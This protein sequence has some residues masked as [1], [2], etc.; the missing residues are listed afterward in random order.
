MSSPQITYTP[1]SDTTPEAE[2]SAL[3]NVYRRI[4]DSAKKR[5]RL[6]D[7]S[8]PEDVKGRSENGFHASNHSTP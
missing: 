4:L 8:G 7:K 2:A 6:P 5:G 1:R 3:A